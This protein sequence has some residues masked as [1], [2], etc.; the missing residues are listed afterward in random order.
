MRCRFPFSL[1]LTLSLGNNLTQANR[2]GL[3][4]NQRSNASAPSLWPARA[5]AKHARQ[6]GGEAGFWF[7]GTTQRAAGGACS[8]PSEG[9]GRRKLRTCALLL[10]VSTIY[11]RRAR[12][13]KH[14]VASDPGGRAS[15]D[16]EVGFSALSF[17]CGRVRRRF[18]ALAEMG[19][20][21]PAPFV[22][23]SESPG[24]PG[25]A[26]QTHGAFR[27]PHQIECQLG[28]TVQGTSESPGQPGR[29][30]RIVGAPKGCGASLAEHLSTPRSLRAT[31][32]AEAPRT[33]L[34]WLA[35]ASP[36]LK[37]RS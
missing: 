29:G 15:F 22:D 13:V 2:N 27:C 23:A 1:S 37:L 7:P 35:H 36:A 26:T 12:I 19:G 6:A 21:L 28:C 33:D 10:A 20:S 9:H 18:A 32:P 3:S 14:V 24:Q 34:Q 17:K 4:S 16:A 8:F 30:T 25:R 31:S 11:A 5:G